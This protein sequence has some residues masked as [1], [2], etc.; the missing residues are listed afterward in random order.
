MPFLALA[1]AVGRMV[2]SRSNSLAETD[3]LPTTLTKKPRK[4]ST[5]PRRTRSGSVSDIVQRRDSFVGKP[6]ARPRSASLP[7][8]MLSRMSTGS[9]PTVGLV[10]QLPRHLLRPPLGTP[11]AQRLLGKTL[12][13]WCHFVRVRKQDRDMI[14]EINLN[15]KQMLSSVQ[16]LE[17]PAV[18]PEPQHRRH[19]HDGTTNVTPTNTPAKMRRQS[20]Q[21]QR[22][23]EIRSEP[24]LSHEALQINQLVAAKECERE[25]LQLQRARRRKP[26]LYAEGPSTARL[27]HEWVPPLTHR[28]ESISSTDSE[29]LPASPDLPPTFSQRAHE[30]VRSASSR[31]GKDVFAESP[32]IA[33]RVASRKTVGGRAQALSLSPEQIVVC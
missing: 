9:T 8:N 21:E 6:T 30:G 29:S 4:A 7:M 14:R 2:R 19:S 16:Q 12:M 11:G 32:R 5:K 15:I 25:A 31:R 10:H 28:S 13:A 1:P 22:R 27:S 3:N 33:A 18:A 23:R 17:V 26:S 24:R 20:L